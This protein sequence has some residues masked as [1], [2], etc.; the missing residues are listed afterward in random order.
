MRILCILLPH[1]PLM[2][3][4]SEQPDLQ[5]RPAVV[6]RAE[7]SQKVVLDCSPGLE[8]L[9]PGMSL[10]QALARYGDARL[11]HADIPRYWSIFDEILDGL[12]ERSPLVEGAGLGCAYVGLDGLQLIYP[13]DGALVAAMREAVPAIFSP[14][15]GTAGN[16]FLAYLAAC[17][18]P[19]GGQYRTLEG[20]CRRFPAGPA[21]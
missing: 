4:V 18:C 14:R 11:L 13:D 3:E 6:T 1:F 9:Q 2:C 21:L 5:G 7:G 19:A 15:L 12:E 17:R 8:D 16:K 10:Q 20:R